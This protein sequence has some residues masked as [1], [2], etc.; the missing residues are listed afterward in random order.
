MKFLKTISIFFLTLWQ[1][2]QCLL[3]AI[4][5][6][7]CRLKK[8][9]SKVYNGRVLT[10]WGLGGG[11]SLGYFIFVSQTASDNTKQHEWG[12]TKQSQFLG[13]LYLLVIGLPSIIWA[14][15]FEKYRQR[16]GVSYYSLFCEKWADK[17]GGVAR[18]I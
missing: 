8:R 7:V 13:W 3:G 5:W 17:L 11:L 14:G 9:T 1:L 2:P 4:I 6:L 10:E 16:N 18:R 12:H 15:C